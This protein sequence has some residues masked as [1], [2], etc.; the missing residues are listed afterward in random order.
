MFLFLFTGNSF[1][2]SMTLADLLITTLLLP[3][4]SVAILGEMEDSEH[5]CRLQYGVGSMSCLTAAIFTAAIGIENFLR[6]K[7][8]SHI[9][10]TRER[11][12]ALQPSSQTT[13]AAAATTTRQH[14]H[15]PMQSN[16]L[17]NQHSSHSHGHP[18]VLGGHTNHSSHNNA[19]TSFSTGQQQQQQRQPSS[20]ARG[21]PNQ[22]PM[23]PSVCTVFQ[24]TLLNLKMWIVSGVIVLIHFIFLPQLM[25]SICGKS[26]QT[27]SLGIPKS[28]KPINQQLLLESL[29][30][31]GV[32]LCALVALGGFGFLKCAFIIKGWKKPTP[33]LTSREIALVATNCWNCLARFLIWTPSII[34]VILIQFSKTL[35]SQ[36]LMS[37]YAYS[38]YSSSSSSLNTVVNAGGGGYSSPITL[39]LSSSVTDNPYAPS[40]TTVLAAVNSEYSFLHKLLIWPMIL[41]SCLASLV[42]IITNQDFRRCYIQLFHYCCCKTSVALSRRPRESTRGGSDV[43][44]HIIPGYNM[45]SSH[46]VSTTQPRFATFKFGPHSSRNTSSG[47]QKRDVY[48]L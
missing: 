3:A 14:H 26:V 20:A 21:E 25:Y 38:S 18:H 4:S 28:P 10:K 40:R 24:V 5:I 32:C 6:L 16:S 35:E 41:P 46:E 31:L 22:P 19:T 29:T 17:L 9:E 11:Q 27:V 13:A 39:S 47:G 7:S 12:Q 15:S 44:V 45:Y 48:E 43:R 2:A 37:P 33:Y 8:L 30:V 1:L 23:K 36:P 34:T 42:N